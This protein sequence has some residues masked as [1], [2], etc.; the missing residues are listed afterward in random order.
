MPPGLGTRLSWQWDVVCW[1]TQ[2]DNL[3]SWNLIRHAASSPSQTPAWKPIHHHGIDL[4]HGRPLSTEEEEGEEE[5]ERKKQ[6]CIVYRS[7]CT[8]ASHLPTYASI[9]VSAI[10]EPSCLKWII[11]QELYMREY[12]SGLSPF[13]PPGL[14]CGNEPIPIPDFSVWKYR[15]SDGKLNCLDVY[16]KQLS[17]PHSWVGLDQIC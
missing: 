1:Y 9:T 6:E 14:E 4:L 8:W 12:N 3:S 10:E 15:K 13:L 17:F 16:G 11:T 5:A 7:C 2:H